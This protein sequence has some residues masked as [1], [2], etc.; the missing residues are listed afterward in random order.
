MSGRKSDVPL[1]K[2]GEPQK[3]AAR[4]PIA[5]LT[6]WPLA[7]QDLAHTEPMQESRQDGG[8]QR[9]RELAPR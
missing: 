2:P 9:D 7:P 4:L 1:L 6:S 8:P 5:R 3:D